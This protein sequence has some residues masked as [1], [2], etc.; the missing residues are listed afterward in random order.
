[1]GEVCGRGVW[2]RCVGE[3]CGSGVWESAV[4]DGRDHYNRP[5]YL[6]FRMQDKRS[7]YMHHSE[8]RLPRL[9]GR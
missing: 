9:S 5:V 4:E 6:P 3:V 1:M 2:E 7:D 8:R